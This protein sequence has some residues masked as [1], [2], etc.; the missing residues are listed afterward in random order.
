MVSSTNHP[1]HRTPQLL[2]HLLHPFPNLLRSGEHAGNSKSIE[3]FDAIGLDY[4]SCSP[5][6]VPVARLASGQS[7]ILRQKGIA[8]PKTKK[9]RILDMSPM[10]DQ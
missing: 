9:G 10:N 5:F 2:P 3:F 4:V 1:R 6:R 7:A 8:S